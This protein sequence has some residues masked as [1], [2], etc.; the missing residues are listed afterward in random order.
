MRRAGKVLVCSAAMR[1]GCFLAILM[2]CLAPA[3]ALRAGDTA[4]AGVRAPELPADPR[5]SGQ[6]GEAALA[7]RA[8]KLREA[9][10]EAV[11]APAQQAELALARARAAQD[12]AARAR[13]LAIA[14]AALALAEARGALLKE[15]ELASSTARRRVEAERRAEK[16]RTL[17]RAAQ[18]VGPQP[19]S[20]KP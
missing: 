16:A 3:A 5:A 4:D 11:R 12:P 18:G 10:D 15:R 8:H 6:G 13:S 14:E 19:A 17:L 20:G 7:A 1:N 9:R 2:T